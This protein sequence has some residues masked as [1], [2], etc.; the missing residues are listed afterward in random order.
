MSSPVQL[1][2]IF[3]YFLLLSIPVAQAQT[4][5][6]TPTSELPRSQITQ[7]QLCCFGKNFVK[8]IYPREARLARTEGVVR[9]TLVIAADGSVANVQAISGDPLL[10]DSTISAVRQ[11][12]LEP[13]LLNGNP[14]EGEVP[15]TFTFSIHDPP[16]PAYLHLINGKVIRTDEVREF[17]DRIEY[18]V[19]HRTLR[20]SGN[21]VVDIDACARAT[22]IPRKE[23]DCIP[24]G[25]PSFFVTA[26]PLLPA[27]KTN[28]SSPASH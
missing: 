3:L 4:Q 15:L 24:A 12:R 14:V 23:G 8:P 2:R 5:S 26:I 11:W 9:L 21:S 6:T 10:V 22:V 19:G 18:R 1:A 20:I 27:A 28:H 25:G 17:T 16:K 7:D 13:T